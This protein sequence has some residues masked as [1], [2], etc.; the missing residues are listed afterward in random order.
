MSVFSPSSLTPPSGARLT[1]S[2]AAVAGEPGEAGGAG[3]AAA[4][5]GGR[6]QGALPRHPHPEAGGAPLNPKS[7][8]RIVRGKKKHFSNPWLRFHLGPCD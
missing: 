7:Q 3:E 6:D 1:G 4:G 5:G 8:I 2:A